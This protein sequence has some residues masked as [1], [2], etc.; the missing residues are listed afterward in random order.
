MS[1]FLA[2]VL[3]KIIS[4]GDETALDRPACI[5]NARRWLGS[6]R[7]YRL[8]PSCLAS[9]RFS[10]FATNTWHQRSH[11]ARPRLGAASPSEENPK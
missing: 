8:Y 3:T 11:W 7:Q 4:V 5:T 2:T 9:T 6:G 1:S 10:S